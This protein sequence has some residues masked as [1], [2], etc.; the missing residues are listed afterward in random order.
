MIATFLIPLTDVSDTAV[1]GILA[2]GAL[3]GLV[4]LLWGRRVG[5]V[6]L[7]LAGAVAG[8]FLGSYVAPM[9]GVNTLAVQAAGAVS[10]ALLCFVLAR[11]IWAAVAAAIC[12]FAAGYILI[13]HFLFDP[14]QLVTELLPGR[15]VAQYTNEVVLYVRPAIEKLWGQNAAVLLLAGG[16]AITIPIVLMLVRPRLLTI[17]TTSLLGTAALVGSLATL[18]A[19]GVPSWRAPM[20]EYWYVVGGVAAAV[21]LTGMV[22]QY[23]HACRKKPADDGDDKGGKKHAK[24]EK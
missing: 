18:T 13:L 16:L 2:M 23:L 24:E 11:L 12:L 17:L 6:L 20:Q 10:I 15:T 22:V 4:L 7:M 14:R 1:G 3:G 19:W 8:V 21:C 5:R 9:L